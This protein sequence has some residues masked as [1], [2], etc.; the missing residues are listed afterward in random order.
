LGWKNRAKAGNTNGT[1]DDDENDGSCMMCNVLVD[2]HWP[3]RESVSGLVSDEY[4][5][6]APALTPSAENGVARRWRHEGREKRSRMTNE[7][8]ATEARTI[9]IV[10]KYRWS[11]GSYLASRLEARPI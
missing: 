8:A 6:E 3:L 10:R 4:G 2:M 9:I 7:V 1:Y 11:N 5:K